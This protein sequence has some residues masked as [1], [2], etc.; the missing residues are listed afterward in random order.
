M[1]EFDQL[2][3]ENRFYLL[4]TKEVNEIYSNLIRSSKDSIQAEGLKIQR[5]IMESL[6]A[7]TEEAVMQGFFGLIANKE[8]ESK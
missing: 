3:F 5:Q 6:H 1:F 2:G 8:G 7:I 4:I